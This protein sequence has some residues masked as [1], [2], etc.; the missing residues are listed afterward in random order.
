MVVGIKKILIIDNILSST[1]IL[2]KDS[3]QTMLEK[4]VDNNRT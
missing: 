2:M 1:I 3:F 4:I